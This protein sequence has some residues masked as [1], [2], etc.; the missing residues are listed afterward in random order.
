MKFLAV[1]I[2]TLVHAGK[3]RTLYIPLKFFLEVCR[4]KQRLMDPND[5]VNEIVCMSKV[6]VFSR[7]AS[8]FKFQL[9]SRHLEIVNRHFLFK[10]T[11]F[12]LNPYQMKHYCN[13]TFVKPVSDEP[14]SVSECELFYSG[15][16]ASDGQVSKKFCYTDKQKFSMHAV[17][18]FLVLYA[19]TLL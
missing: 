9:V 3:R 13:S 7:T 6:R 14:I 15:Y 1:F 19:L 16:R 10:K 8:I 12:R 18:W 11:Y 5:F 2:F 4:Q 17:K